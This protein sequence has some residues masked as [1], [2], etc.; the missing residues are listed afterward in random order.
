MPASS[1]P[2]FPTFEKVSSE[3]TGARYI[4]K[5]KNNLQFS[6]YFFLPLTHFGVPFLHLLSGV[7]SPVAAVHEHSELLAM[8]TL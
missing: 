5:I 2:L 3:V 6:F 4:L 7:L 8:G 1:F